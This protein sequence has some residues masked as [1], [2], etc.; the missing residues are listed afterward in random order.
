M[1]SRSIK[2]KRKEGAGNQNL[3]LGLLYFLLSICAYK[4]SPLPSPVTRATITPTL[5]AKR[6]RQLLA[7]TA[8]AK[9][10]SPIISLLLPLQ[11]ASSNSLTPS[12]LHRHPSPRSSAAIR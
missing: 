8:R 2:K 10:P 6:H 4:A 9:G 5:T 1:M 7:P 12:Q 11:A 3:S